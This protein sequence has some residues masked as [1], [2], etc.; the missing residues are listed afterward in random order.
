MKFNEPKTIKLKAITPV[1]IGNGETLRPISYVLDGN[2]VHVLDE[3]RFFAQFSAEQL[4]AYQKWINP[5]LDK[6]ANL[7]EQVIQA[8]SD[9]ETRRLLLR[10]R[11]DIES[12]L[13][14]SYFLL[15]VL[16]IRAREFASR[17]AAYQVR[18]SVAPERDG[19]KVHLKDIA[20]RP[21]ISGS[22]IKGALRS[23]LLYAILS[24]QNNYQK[25]Q[26]SLQRFRSELQSGLPL[27]EKM[28]RLRKISDDLEA[29]F[30]RG[31]VRGQQKND[32]KYDFLR[33]INVADSTSL[34]TSALCIELTQNMG[35]GR[36]TRTWVE[37]IV[38][39]ST[40]STRMALADPAL[41]LS[42]LG[43]K[44]L[45]QWLSLPKILEACFIRSRDILAEEAEYFAHE[46]EIRELISDLQD[47]NQPQS[48]LLRLGQGQGFLGVTLDLLVKNRDADLYDSTIREG[49]SLQRRWRT[50]KGKFPKTR[51][52]LIDKNN[53][54]LNL[55]GWI[56]F[57]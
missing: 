40:V 48:P 10:Q 24:E 57:I 56:K 27:R 14:V 29:E 8:G 51:R 20:H 13:S 2:T 12:Q 41:I 50:Q 46:P 36:Y 11:R 49:V 54:P 53:A 4:D 28:K 9:F 45:M 32:A 35:T 38:A 25:L 6:I 30:L 39:D 23:S 47:Q 7:D 15:N 16:H 55:L 43:L 26:K 52:A 33:F 44:K 34:P 19:F 31:F 17:C 5:L 21:Y 42:E 18:C 37:T 22:E 1:F 3:N